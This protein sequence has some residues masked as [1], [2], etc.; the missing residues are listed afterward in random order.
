MLR[1]IKQPLNTAS[2]QS[3]CPGPDLL[4]KG[5][6][7]RP[8]TDLHEKFSRQAALTFRKKSRKQLL[9]IGRFR[10]GIES[11][12]ASRTPHSSLKPKRKA[13]LLLQQSWRLNIIANFSW[14]PALYLAK[15]QKAHINS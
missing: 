2:Q 9:P 13:A 15:A 6:I 8:I 12:L 4:G 5:C 11:W 10:S 7:L 1:H 3:R 14:F